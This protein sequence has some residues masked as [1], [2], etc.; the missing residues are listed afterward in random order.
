MARHHVIIGACL[1]H[2]HRARLA[3][4]RTSYA[5]AAMQVDIPDAGSPRPHL[6]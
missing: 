5:L 2:V 4:G 1:A 6:L 3:Q